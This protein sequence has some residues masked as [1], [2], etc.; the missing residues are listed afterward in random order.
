[1]ER[2]YSDGWLA[3]QHGV[4]DVSTFSGVIISFLAFGIYWKVDIAQEC[5]KIVFLISEK[6]FLIKLYK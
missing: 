6:L 2:R 1:M 3:I 4:P 5:S